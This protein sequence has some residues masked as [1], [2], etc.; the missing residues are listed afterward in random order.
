[1]KEIWEAGVLPL[2]YSRSRATVE[3]LLCSPS[4]ISGKHRRALAWPD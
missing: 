3:A 4:A 2:N 1:M